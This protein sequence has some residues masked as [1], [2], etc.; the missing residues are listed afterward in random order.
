LF[1]LELE[2][3]I[4]L[5]KTTNVIFFQILVI[6]TACCRNEIYCREQ[7]KLIVKIVR[8]MTGP[9]ANLTKKYLGVLRV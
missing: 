1:E 8:H 5:S 4:V 3:V 6:G 7:K 2:L 9:D